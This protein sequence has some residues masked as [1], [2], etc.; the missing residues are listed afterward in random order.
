M[1]PYRRMP[2]ENTSIT[3]SDEKKALNSSD[4]TSACRADRNVKASRNRPYSEAQ[5]IALRSTTRLSRSRAKVSI[6]RRVS[7]ATVARRR[8]KWRASSSN[9]SSRTDATG[10]RPLMAPPPARAGR[11]AA[12]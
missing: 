1:P 6:D 10:A 12:T 2:V 3:I 5:N 7:Q 4:T 11:P 8:R 9:P